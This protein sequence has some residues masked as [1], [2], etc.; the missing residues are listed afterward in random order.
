[1]PL[2]I[3]N[4]VLI[5][6]SFIS[7]A[8]RRRSPLRFRRRCWLLLIDGCFRRQPLISSFSDVYYVIAAMTDITSLIRH[9]YFFFRCQ[10]D[11]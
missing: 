3:A 8:G 2:L 11:G 6:R 1:M 9:Y 10:I 5:L 7:F 4:S